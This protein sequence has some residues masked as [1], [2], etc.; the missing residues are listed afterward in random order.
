MDDIVVWGSASGTTLIRVFRLQKEQHVSRDLHMQYRTQDNGTNIDKTDWNTQ[1][2]F[3]IW[4]GTFNNRARVIRN[5][6]HYNSTTNSKL[7]L[8]IFLH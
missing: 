1:P 8:N 6:Q 3:R 4:T 7:C 5:E 2:H